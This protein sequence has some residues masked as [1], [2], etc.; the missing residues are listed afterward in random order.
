LPDHRML[1]R[2]TEA[3]NP[4]VPGA[5]AIGASSASGESAA[6]SGPAPFIAA[7]TTRRLAVLVLFVGLF[8]TVV[9]IHVDSGTFAHLR[10]GAWILE[11]GR[12]TGVDVFSHTASG[13][14]WVNS[15]WLSEVIM[16]VIHRAAGYAGLNLVTSLVIWASLLV[17]YRSGRADTYVRALATALAA[18]TM[19]IGW[20]AQPQVATFLLV[21][22]FNLILIR[23]RRGDGNRLWLLPPL[24]VLWANLHDGFAF[25]LVLLGV[26]L[27]GELATV[28][29]NRLRPERSE[30]AQR[31]FAIPFQV[32]AAG[33]ACLLA[34]GANPHGYA[35]L[36]VP[37]T[38]FSMGALHG[39]VQAWQSPDFHAPAAQFF[40]LL[41]LVTFAVVGTTRRRLE[42][43]DLLVFAVFSAAA[44][45]AARNIAVFAIVA[46]P[47][48]MRH[49]G[50][51]VSEFEDY[52]VRRGLVRARPRATLAINWI[53]LS[54]VL[55][56]TAIKV[57]W[58]LSAGATE[59][60]IA[61]SF[62]VGAVTFLRTHASRGALFNTYGF[63]GFLSWTLYPAH[64][65]F[66]DERDGVY[67]R[68]ILDAYARTY[69]AR[70]GY[71]A[72][73]SRYGIGVVMVDPDAP[74]AQA[75]Q[76][77]PEWV[78][79]YRDWMSVVIFRRH[80]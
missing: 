46:A 55:V 47:I 5:T 23:H 7:L 35:L 28:L 20:S 80:A 17:V 32:G 74:L 68:E 25:G 9:G 16:T 48:L 37:L 59:L 45:M 71:D 11:H 10:S 21:A 53:L 39:L 3:A 22:V 63:G 43:T 13:R 75:L 67:G 30:P 44:L 15:A 40:I 1:A 77:S 19:A 79:R 78:V 33:V 58:P 51:L 36:R 65:V 72:T 60:T 4:R 57:E 61:R 69:M 2:V 31:S 6:A 73:L 24:M 52:A 76:A 70:P 56:A 50:A 66:V 54:L 42:A 64:P 12:L 38:T 41:W 14:P 26:T 27:A 62:P 49:G 29:V 18:T 34:T 8:A